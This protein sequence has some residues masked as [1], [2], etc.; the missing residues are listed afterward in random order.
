VT[1]A[2]SG[3]DTPGAVAGA[4]AQSAQGHPAALTALTAL[5]RDSIR[6]YARSLGVDLV[7][8]ASVAELE[9]ELPE[10]ARPSTLAHGMRTFVVL[11]K[12]TL[13]G[14]TWARHL[15]SKQLA[16][17]RNLRVLDHASEA[18][19]RAFESAG[20]LGVPISSAALD[21][22]RRGPLDLTP[23]GQGS[24]LL[25]HAA[26]AGGLGTWGLNLMILTREFGPRVHLG[27]VMTTLA[28]EP[29]PRIET[30][31]C[32]GLEQCGRC[33]AICPEDAI[34][35]RAPVGAGPAAC[36]GLD[37]AAC[38]RSSQPFGFHAFTEHLG[39]II[40]GGEAKEMWA[41]MRN[42]KTGEM[43]SEMAMMKEAALTGCS[44]C[45]QVCPVG[46]DFD[47]IKTTPHRRSDLPDPLPHTVV[48]GTVE[49]PNLG[50]QVRRKLTWDRDVKK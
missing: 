23:A 34:P 13:R 16:G 50:P 26:V 19:A 29:D 49:V 36:R 45:V 24:P 20:E 47:A 10:N 1:V 25:R 15:P 37:A 3:P 42:R 32:L 17:G 18:L 48:D 4:L 46:A 22:A 9:A 31:L 2:R 33:A 27:G 5:D 44:E 8:F 6:A 28:L 43:W 12:R 21:F 41:R 35:R 39:Q 30:E 40:E 14:V 11:A 7:G 38:A